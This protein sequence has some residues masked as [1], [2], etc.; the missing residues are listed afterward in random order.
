MGLD[1]GVPY[2]TEVRAA[3]SGTVVYSDDSIPYYNA[4]IIISHDD[5]FATC[6]AQNSRLLVREGQR[7]QQGQV[8]AR[9]GNS[10]MGGNPYLHF[11]L[12]KN[13]EA[14]NPEPYLP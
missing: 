7:V 9:S 1:I 8:I 3:R 11:E 6:Y 14:V 13:S 10:G 5:G 12:R 2:G 4:M